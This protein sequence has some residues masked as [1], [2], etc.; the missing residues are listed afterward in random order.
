LY[1]SKNNYAIST[2]ISRISQ[3][4]NSYQCHVV[5]P[6]NL[7]VALKTV[8]LLLM[9]WGCRHGD[10]QTYWTCSKWPSWTIKVIRNLPCRPSGN[11]FH[12]NTST[13]WCRSSPSAWLPA[14]L[15][16]SAV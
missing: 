11:S 7:L 4:S 1:I 5:V 3:Q 8:S 13:R 15:Q 6:S 16:A 9:R 10:S 14:W 12:N 2:K